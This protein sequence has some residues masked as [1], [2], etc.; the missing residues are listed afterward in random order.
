MDGPGVEHRATIDH[1]GY[2]REEVADGSAPDR[3]V[4]GDE[5]E[6][7]AVAAEDGG[8]PRLAQ[9]RGAL[10]HRVEHRLDVGRRAADHPEDVGG[11]RLLLERD[12]QLGVA[13]LQLLEQADVL[14]GDDGLVGEG[15]EQLDLV[16]REP[17]GLARHR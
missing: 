10:G 8:I 12:P 16:V 2:E 11:G 6:P 3:T 9:A 14:D 7:I 17:P 13:R 15:L 5:K 4:M 1:P